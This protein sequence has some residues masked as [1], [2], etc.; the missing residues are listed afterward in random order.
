MCSA[1]TPNA[2]AMALASATSAAGPQITQRVS[3]V[4]NILPI[5]SLF[6]LPRVP[7][8]SVVVSLVIVRSS[9]RQQLTGVCEFFRASRAIQDAE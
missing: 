5:S 8:Q 9:Q 2:L 4:F 7:S 1:L 6:N 3:G